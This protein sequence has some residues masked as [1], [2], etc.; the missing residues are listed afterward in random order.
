MD[1][2]QDI[3][4]AP[5]LNGDQSMKPKV[6]TQSDP[7]QPKLEIALESELFKSSKTETFIDLISS[8]DDGRRGD[9]QKE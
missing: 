3:A 6:L 1:A 5:T 4:I 9:D 2:L 8:D 7:T